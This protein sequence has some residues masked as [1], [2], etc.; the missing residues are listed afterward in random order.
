LSKGHAVLVIEDET[1]LARNIVAYLRRAGYDAEHADD[2][3]QGLARLDAFRPDVVVLDYN[4]PGMNGI[5]ALHR[6]RALDARVKVIMITGHGN[7]KVAVEAMKASALDYITKPVLLSELKVLIAKAIGDERRDEAVAHV[8]RATGGTGLVAIIGESAP[9]LALK[10]T[11]AKLV[12]AEANAAGAPPPVLIT[13]ETGAGKE[14]VARAV[15]FEGARAARPFVE[16]N[17]GAIPGNLLESELFG[18]ERGAFTDARERKIGLIEAAD[19][20]TLFLDEIGDM[21]LALQVKLLRVLEERVIRRL[22]S[23]RD[24]PVDV[25]V[26]S[27]TNRSL[28]TLVAAGRFRSDL[29]FRLR[30]V[31]L[32]APP[33]RER[34]ADSILLARHFLARFAAHYARRGLALTADA[35]GA[36]CAY[37]WPGNVRELRNVIEQAVLLAPGA[38]IDAAMLRLSPTEAETP[39]S[40]SGGAR[41]L[42]EVE[43]E[44]VLDALTR[45]LWNVSRAAQLL[46]ISRD[47]MRYRMAKFGL[48]R[49]EYEP[50]RAADVQGKP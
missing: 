32:H 12:R 28:E 20:G 19:G 3:E 7:V 2:A 22:G 37:A 42:E 44:M 49:P 21:E 18:H 4:L 35:E 36:I 16:I 29:L 48:R 11:I 34:G 39:P 43:R 15:H 33:L 31:T 47:T 23:I 5:D 17:C 45:T 30:I 38:A 6:I 14:L 13:G 41:K 40:S 9:I 46:G 8:Q 24:R 1:T 27:A 10:E 25:R 26:V 50:L